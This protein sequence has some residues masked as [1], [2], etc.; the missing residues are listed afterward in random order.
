M[1]VLVGIAGGIGAGKSVVSRILDAMGYPV[2][3]CDSRAKAIMDKDPGMHEQLCRQIHPL[4]IIGGVIDRLLAE[5]VFN[6]PLALG[7]LNTIV[8]AAVEADVSR[9]VQQQG[10]NFTFVESAILY[11]CRLAGMVDAVIEVTAPVE[12]RVSR[13]VKRSGLTRRQIL[14]RIA[15]QPAP[16]CRHAHTF[17]IVND[18]VTPILPQI[19]R[20]IDAITSS[21]F[22]AQ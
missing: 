1:T 10:S 4:V 18:D 13:V 19:H 2:Y 20:V 8:H 17:E 5:I 7:R 9:W 12:L 16:T 3:D 6:D 14:D 21:A 15:S 22:I 11:Q